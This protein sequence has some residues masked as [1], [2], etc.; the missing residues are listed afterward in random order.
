M[1]PAFTYTWALVA[2]LVS[3]LF[4]ALPASAVAQPIVRTAVQPQSVEVGGYVN[5]SLAIHV[6]SNQ[7]IEVQG[8]PDF[9]DAFQIAGTSKSPGYMV[10]N[11]RAIQRL[12]HTYKLRA[13]D[14][15]EH[16]IRPPKV[17]VGGETVEPDP[18]TVRVRARGQAPD[19]RRR[20]SRA[21]RN[22]NQ[23][24]P[25]QQQ[26]ERVFIDH[27][28]DPTSKPYVGEQVTL[29]Y[30]L[31]ADAFRLKVNPEPP[32]EPSLDDFWIEDLSEEFSGRR[33]SLRINGKM[34]ERANLRAYALFPLRAGTSRIE[35]LEVDV[36]VGGFMRRTHKERLASKPI[37]L[38]VQPLPPDAP[39]SFYEGN[40]GRWQF[41]VTTDRMRAAM[42]RPITVRVSASGNGQLGR[43]SLPK[44]PAIDGARGAGTQEEID[45][46]T[47]NG[48]IG[49]KKA[50]EYTIVPE[51]EGTIEIPSLEFSYFD[52]KREAYETIETEPIEIEVKGG[53]LDLEHQA[54]P[55]T[56]PDDTRE[57]A[58]LLDTLVAKLAAPRESVSAR[59]RAPFER[60]PLLW[61]L[62]AL[63][64]LGVAAVWL[65]APIR[66]FLARPRR[67]RRGH[68]YK[69]A[70]AE[71][72]AARS[73]PPA[74]TLDRVRDALTTYVTDNA[75]LSAGAVSESDLP[76]QLEKRGV[77]SELAGRLGDLLRGLNEARYSPDK[78]AMA[79]QATEL[80]EECESCIEALEEG[81]RA[82]RWS[83]STAASLLLAASIATAG[84]FAPAPAH[85]DNP[86]SPEA[87]DKAV[88]AQEEGQWQ[89][90][91]K[92][93]K[94][95]DEER[96]GSPDIL[97]NLGTALAHAGDFGQAR[98]AF[99]RAA[100]HAP[101]DDQIEQ[102]RDLVQQIVHLRQIEL[103]RGTVRENTT[104]EGLF[105]WRLA[106][107]VSPHW[108]LALLIALAWL[109]FLS[110]L[111]RKFAKS[112]AARDAGLSVGVICALLMVLNVG[113]WLAHG[114]VLADFQ[115]AVVVAEETSLREGPSEHAGL[116]DIDTI[117]VP[118]VLLCVRDTRD[119][120]VKLGFSDGTAAWTPR[121]NVALVE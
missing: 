94:H 72:D 83:A 16:T 69:E 106:T 18:V 22:R 36:R 73:S 17:Q 76:A 4:I 104:S 50:I 43:I 30:Y 119:G 87:L 62:L 81:R 24:D 9:G 82:K 31:Y 105:W 27:N 110:S 35:P 25:N 117:L 77:D 59:P 3:T 71:L 92:L 23:G 13:I 33:Q 90:A 66:A 14:E 56:E 97:Y 20:S 112:S 101:G 55:S 98:L 120:W 91:A 75:G 121:E 41:Q 102:N 1:R 67:K 108:L 38:D 21:Q 61:I 60:S 44:L 63:P 96:P 65:A 57:E 68:G 29:A 107:S 15:G 46:R 109:V 26:D 48:V 45:K 58:A 70:L 115:P 6:E 114:Q 52:P 51:R 53:S 64:T 10:R 89:D 32:D 84:V 5:F 80:R 103:A 2:L 86:P 95:L 79:S 111:A 118:G 49:G 37:E 8:H 19:D 40:V 74:E 42:G 34:M 39:D 85:A 100:L 88:Q 12:T 113:V 7:P 99:E 116:A 28:I 11:G 54:A 93:W 78:A 47:R